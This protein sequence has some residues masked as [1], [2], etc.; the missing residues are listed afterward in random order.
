MQRGRLPAAPVIFLDT[1]HMYPDTVLEMEAAWEALKEKARR[2]AA[3][4][5]ARREA[6]EKMRREAEEAARRAAQP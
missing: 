6:E 5:A 4:E 3:A 2:E 1:A